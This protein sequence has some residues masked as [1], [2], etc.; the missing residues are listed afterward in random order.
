MT[1][2]LQAA[3]WAPEWVTN[4]RLD[5]LLRLCLALVLGGII[6][7]ERELSGK[8]AGL[9]TNILICVGATLLTELSIGVAAL[10][11]G[12]GFRSDPARIAAQIVSGVGF[13]GAGTILRSRGS[14]TGLTSAA[15]LWVVAAIGMAVGAHAY[16]EATGT[17]A[18]VIVALVLLA[19]GEEAIKG[20]SSTRRYA[21]SVD[22]DF[23]LL[24]RVESAMRAAGL[25]VRTDALEKHEGRF[26]VLLTVTGRTPAQE[27]V[28]R[29]LI[30][31]PG[32]HR[33]AR[34]E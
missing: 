32:V 19:R 14:I 28:M 22:P 15:T 10:S 12:P 33:M 23:D 3:S 9:R 1:A 24:Q 17:T 26:S 34:G 13:I 2:L 31:L 11:D 29:E 27:A 16:V 18:L 21:L 7:L 6:G 25:R 20:R 30:R 4:F 8:P 5:L